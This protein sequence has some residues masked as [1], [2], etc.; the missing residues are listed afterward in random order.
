GPAARWGVIKQTQSLGEHKYDAMFV[1][2]EK[3]FANRHQYLF[4]YPL[5][6]QD[7][8]GGVTAVTDFYNPDLDWGPGNADRRHAFVA[9]GSVM[10]PHEIALGVVFNLKSTARF[11]ST[12]GRD[13]NRD[14]TAATDYGPGT[15]RNMTHAW[16][17]S[18]RR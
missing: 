14:G 4:S 13:L 15:T 9:S 5:A 1:R 8:N 6:K 11:N 10:L 3:R 2:L 17:D 18:F 12:A 16:S 7:N